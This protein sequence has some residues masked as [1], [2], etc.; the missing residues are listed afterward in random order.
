MISVMSLVLGDPDR[1]AVRAVKQ[2]NCIYFTGKLWWKTCF[3]DVVA[4]Y[5]K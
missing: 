2:G 4:A 1:S 3:V 5:I